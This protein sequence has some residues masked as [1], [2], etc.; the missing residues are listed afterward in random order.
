MFSSPVMV[1]RQSVPATEESNLGYR[2]SIVQGIMRAAQWDGKHFAEGM[3]LAQKLLSNAENNCGRAL[4]I[5]SFMS[6]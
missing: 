6:E 5:L 2:F 3:K 4:G 1:G